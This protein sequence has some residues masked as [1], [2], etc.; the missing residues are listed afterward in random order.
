MDISKIKAT[1]KLPK[2][3]LGKTKEHYAVMSKSGGWGGSGV[4]RYAW[5]WIIENPV[6][7]IKSDPRLARKT[8]ATKAQVE[9]ITQTSLK[10][11][12]NLLENGKNIASKGGTDGKA[13]HSDA[14][15]EK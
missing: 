12:V 15:G 10:E 6:L 1:I 3:E 14:K 13:V 5:S 8:N 4:K 9:F 7:A 11:L 2:T